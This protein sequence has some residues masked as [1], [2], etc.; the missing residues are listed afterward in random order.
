MDKGGRGMP[1]PHMGHATFEQVSKNYT[2]LKKNKS[3]AVAEMAVQ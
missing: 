3:S 1:R 2:V